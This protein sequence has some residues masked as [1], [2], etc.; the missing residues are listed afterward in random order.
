MDRTKVTSDAILTGNISSI[1]FGSQVGL[2]GES[3]TFPDE[4]F[5]GTTG[6]GGEATGNHG[7]GIKNTIDGVSP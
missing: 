1:E 6:V 2:Q 4:S 7:I 5:V 3:E